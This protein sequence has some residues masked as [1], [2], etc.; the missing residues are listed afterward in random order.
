MDEFL[1]NQNVGRTVDK[2]NPFTI[3][4]GRSR[5]K[6]VDSIPEPVD[7]SFYRLLT[8]VR[9][10]PQFTTASLGIEMTAGEDTERYLQ[11]KLPEATPDFVR[12]VVDEIRKP[13]GADSTAAR[14][15]RGVF[16]AAKVG[17][18]TL[19]WKST[20]QN[21]FRGDKNLLRLSSDNYQV[22]ED[23]ELPIQNGLNVSLYNLEETFSFRSYSQTLPHKLS[24]IHI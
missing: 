18:V 2:G 24:L 13:F 14:L 22:P 8:A 11:L 15:A 5:D 17:V 9:E 7:D 1:I 12:Q 20:N 16:R 21:W 19:D 3:E 10:S 6:I 23:L 4:R